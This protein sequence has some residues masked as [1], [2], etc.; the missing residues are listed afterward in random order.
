M[1]KPTNTPIDTT[2]RHLLTIA[3][4]GAV[5]AAIP[6]DA[7]AYP[8]PDPIYAAIDAHRKAAAVEQAV[9]AEFNRL[10]EIADEKVGPNE[11]EIPSMIEPGTTV[12]A[13]SWVD[14]ERAIL[15]KE[16]EDLWV[17]HFT[18]LEDRRA[19]RAAIIGDENA[20]TDGPNAAANDAREKFAGRIPTTLPGLLAMIVYAS[21]LDDQYPEVFSDC[22]LTLATAA[23]ALLNSMK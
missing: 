15:S 8:G 22:R 18:L 21:E 6:A 7:R 16:Y 13:S 11:I 5:A 1:T 20:G 2:R 3:A 9:W 23:Q 17:H 14:I 19:A 10:S 4:G 12:R